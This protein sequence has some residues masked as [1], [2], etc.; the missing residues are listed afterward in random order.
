L[1]LLTN[2]QYGNFFIT[3]KVKVPVY[4]LLNIPSQSSCK[5]KQSGILTEYVNINM[6]C[7]ANIIYVLTM[8]SSALYFYKKQTD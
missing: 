4:P 7:C 8:Y 1:R 2:S 3:E 6:L 5:E